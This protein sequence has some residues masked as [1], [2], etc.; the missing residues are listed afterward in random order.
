[1]TLSFVPGTEVQG[2]PTTW[3]AEGNELYC[4]SCRRERA[5]ELGLADLPIDAPAEERQRSRSSARVEFE[6]TRDPS[7]QDNRIAKSCHTSVVA[8]RKA[9]VRLGLEDVA[10]V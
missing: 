2:L 4:L 1:M 6:I 7:R 5:G 8:V 3:S 9:R 10:R